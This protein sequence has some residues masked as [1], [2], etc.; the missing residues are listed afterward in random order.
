MSSPSQLSDLQLS[1]MQVLWTRDEAT[2]AEVHAALHVQR[3]LAMT[4]IATLL[5]RL[6]KRGL[7]TH[8]AHGRQFVYRAS[9][10][11]D[12]VRVHQ[13][14]RLTDKLFRGD[15]TELVCHLLSD[16][17]LEPGDLERV[18]AL[19]RDHEQREAQGGDDDDT[20]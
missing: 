20:A 3:G 1:V 6:E 11:E 16:R 9:V 17:D 18:R 15:V 8:R 19:L 4:T 14:S 13:V 10:T 7:V 5:S 12:E 2:V